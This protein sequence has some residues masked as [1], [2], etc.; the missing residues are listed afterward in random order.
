MEHALRAAQGGELG[1]GGALEGVEAGQ[2]GREGPGGEAFLDGQAQGD[3]M[4]GGLA[5]EV[6]EQMAQLVEVGNGGREEEG[7]AGKETKPARDVSIVLT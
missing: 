3:V 5:L 1:M 7:G 4:V 2:R 6:V